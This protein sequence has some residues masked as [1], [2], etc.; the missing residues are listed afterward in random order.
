MHPEIYIAITELS[1]HRGGQ[2]P[3]FL[4]QQSQSQSQLTFH[5]SPSP[6]SSQILRYGAA[7][8]KIWRDLTLRLDAATVAR[9]YAYWQISTLLRKSSPYYHYWVLLWSEHRYLSRLILQC[10]S[11]P[12]TTG[13]RPGSR[14][15]A[16]RVVLQGA[17]DFPLGVQS[18][19]LQHN[20]P[21]KQDACNSVVYLRCK[22]SGRRMHLRERT[23]DIR[24]QGHGMW[25]A[26][27]QFR[28]HDQAVVRRRGKFMMAGE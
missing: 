4:L 21:L 8:A 19:I 3:V 13:Q 26:V 18:L 23:H 7:K 27:Q 5:L 1:C 15:Q 2:G 11:Y 20:S 10:N 12:H 16:S 25:F 17:A 24:C 6:V 9:A 22:S 28:W 14:Y